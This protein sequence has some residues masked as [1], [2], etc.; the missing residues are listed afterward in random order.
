M[1]DVRNRTSEGTNPKGKKVL[2]SADGFV[3]PSE[4]RIKSIAL[5]VR[6]YNLPPAMMKEVH[7]V[8]PGNQI[9]KFIR[10]DGTFPGYLRVRVEFPLL[11]ALMPSLTV[12]IRGRG[13]MVINL[14]YENVLHFCFRCGRM[15]HTLVNC[16]AGGVDDDSVQFGEE[17]RASPPR[18]VREINLK[19]VASR[20]IK[21]LFQVSGTQARVAS[22]GD[23]GGGLHA[24]SAN[25]GPG[26]R[27]SREGSA[28]APLGNN[29]SAHLLRNVISMDPAHEVK[30]CTWTVSRRM[31]VAHHVT[32]QGGKGF[33]SGPTCHPRRSQRITAR[34]KWLGYRRDQR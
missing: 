31:L 7:A 15:G 19:Q 12:R 17:L 30:I 11:K 34:L 16:D 8:Q 29:I 10:M 25:S 27:R 14:K 3:R 28:D 22:P 33:L 24:D 13:A 18:R 23:Q 32:L 21:P 20:V 1:M 2:D 4:I 6:L 26:S 9:G 5:W